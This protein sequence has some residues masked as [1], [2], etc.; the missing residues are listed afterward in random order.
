MKLTRGMWIA[1]WIVSVLLAL[2]FLFIGGVKVVMPA[3]DMASAS[4]GVPVVLL[5]I[6]GIAEVLGALG[7]ILPAATRILPVLTP[8]AAAGL[9]LTM[10]GATIVDISLG[11]YPV[12]A[13]TAL[14]GVLAGFVAWARFG[15]AAITPR[16]PGQPTL[17]TASG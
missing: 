6:A 14:L 17:D 7:I 8:I 15:P 2:A 3:A 9:V 1:V 12:A 16:Q 10:A 5:K 11:L 13:Q 4:H